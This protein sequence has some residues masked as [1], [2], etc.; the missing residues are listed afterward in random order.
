[1]GEDNFK[2]YVC[3]S[4]RTQKE[5]KEEGFNCICEVI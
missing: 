1:M 4:E 3:G 5:I 2:C